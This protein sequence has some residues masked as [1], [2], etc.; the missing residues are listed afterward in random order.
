M[1][2]NWPNSSQTSPIRWPSRCRGGHRWRSAVVAGLRG[3]SAAADRH[4]H[5]H[6]RRPVARGRRCQG[7]RKKTRG[8][9]GGFAGLTRKRASA[10]AAGSRGQCRLRRAPPPLALF[11]LRRFGCCPDGLYVSAPARLAPPSSGPAA[12]EFPCGAPSSLI[13]SGNFPPLA[14]RVDRPPSA[15]APQA[16]PAAKTTGE[17]GRWPEQPGPRPHP[18]PS[19]LTDIEASGEQGSWPVT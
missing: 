7:R 14:L 2:P 9:D 4:S 13:S 5:T 3:G 15:T 6:C 8:A 19:R 12:Q 1:R 17:R 11:C 18:F 10:G 16:S